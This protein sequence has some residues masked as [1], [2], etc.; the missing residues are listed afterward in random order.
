MKHV[1]LFEDFDL[2]KFLQDP[3]SEFAKNEDN[4]ELEPGD[5][6]DTYRGHG[7]LLSIDGE[8][9][10][11]KF[12]GSNGTIAKVPVFSL[13]KIKKSSVNTEMPNTEAEVKQLAD[14]VTNYVNIIEDDDLESEPAQINANSALDF[15]EDILLD[16]ISLQ[17][18]DPDTTR[19][20]AYSDLMNGVSVLAYYS[21]KYGGEEYDRSQRILSEFQRMSEIRENQQRNY[22]RLKALGLASN[23]FIDVEAVQP[24]EKDM[25]RA[26]GLFNSYGFDE[27]KASRMA[28]LI[29]EPMK[30]VR[31]VKAVCKVFVNHRDTRYYATTPEQIKQR[32]THKLK[33]SFRQPML[34]LGF[35]DAQIEQIVDQAIEDN[36]AVSEKKRLEWHDSNAP[37]ANGKFKELGV[38]ALANWLIKTRGRNLQKISGSLNQQ[39]NF[40]KKKNPSYAAKMEKTRE[41][42]KRKLGRSDNK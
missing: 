12:T 39:I 41:A 18:K 26:N 15:L 17:K 20:S 8:F 29:K 42:V 9:A 32:L 14:Q 4:P 36:Y 19:V 25:M 31:R 34:N 2:D 6:V 23:N 37:D 24:E 40:N 27:G 35:T 28:Q 30:M 10:K 7:Q 1:K 38:N 21:G 22:N 13:K 33:W 3:D 5:W 16:I 11:I